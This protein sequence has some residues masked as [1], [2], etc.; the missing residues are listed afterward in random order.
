M[1]FNALPL[2]WVPSTTQQPAVTSKI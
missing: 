1:D 2:T